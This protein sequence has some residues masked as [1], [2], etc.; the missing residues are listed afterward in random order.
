M[1]FSKAKVNATDRIST[2]FR[3]FTFA[4]ENCMLHSDKKKIKGDSEKISQAF[5]N[6]WIK[7]NDKVNMETR[8]YHFCKEEKIRL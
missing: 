4:S 8:K 5:V 6:I 7:T 2:R 3:D 1:A